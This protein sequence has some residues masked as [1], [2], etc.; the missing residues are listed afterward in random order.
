MASFHLAICIRKFLVDFEFKICINV[1]ESQFFGVFG[2]P[3]L[4]FMSAY[5]YTLSSWR[6]KKL[7]QKLMC[8]NK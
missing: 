8:S 4:V 2:G 5:V 6:L 7:S 3:R 1:A